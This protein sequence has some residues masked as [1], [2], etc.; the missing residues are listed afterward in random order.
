VRYVLHYENRLKKWY[1]LCTGS[2]KKSSAE[3]SGWWKG[4]RG[5]M[6]AS[7]TTSMWCP[8]TLKRWERKGGDAKSTCPHHE[9]KKAASK[10]ASVVALTSGPR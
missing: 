3:H 8:A 10:D 5:S 2:E 1:K 7:F 4:A 9:D 6:A